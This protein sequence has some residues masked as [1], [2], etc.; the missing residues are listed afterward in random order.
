VFPDE[1]DGQPVANVE[2][3]KFLESVCVEGGQAGVD[4]VSSAAPRTV[5]LAQVFIASA[6]A[7]VEATPLRI[8]AFRVQ[9]ATEDELRDM[10]AGLAQSVG[11]DPAKFA[12]ELPDVQAGGKT[13]QTWT[14]AEGESSYLYWI[15]DIVVVA[16]AVTAS[17]ADRIF[18]AFP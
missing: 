5:D 6:E 3:G 18:A 1:I 4:A 2:S 12:E 13:V 7:N 8:G 15:G 11:G 16:D 10:L 9:D 14:N 17:Q